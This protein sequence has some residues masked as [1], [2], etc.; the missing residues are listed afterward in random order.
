[1]NAVPGPGRRA[2]EGVRLWLSVPA[3]ILALLVAGLHPQVAS[4]AMPDGSDAVGQPVQRVLSY[5]VAGAGNATDISGFSG[6]VAEI[7]A[8]HRGWSLGGSLSFRQV[9]SGGDFVLWLAAPGS[10]PGFSPGCSAQWSCRAGD[11][12]IINE[13]RWTGG[14]DAWAATGASLADYQAMVINHEVGHLLGFDHAYCGAEGSPAP[15]MQ[16][17]SKGMQGCA[18]NPWPT[19]AERSSLAALYGLQVQP[20]PAA[21]GVAAA[22]GDGPQREVPDP[23]WVLLDTRLGIGADD[24]VP[25]RLKP[26]TTAGVHVGGAGGVRGYLQR[27][28]VDHVALDSPGGVRLWTTAGDSLVV[29]VGSQPT[30]HTLAVGPDGMVFVAVE[31]QFGWAELVLT[32]VGGGEPARASTTA[33][34]AKLQQPAGWGASDLHPLVGQGTPWPMA[35]QVSQGP[36]ADY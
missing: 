12:V 14:T 15:V 34:L 20:L 1:M 29:P 19:D 35:G 4:A 25:C 8:N 16:Q 2:L 3:L 11:D 17:Q 24:P 22:S 31:S 18:P 30:E 13:A 27:V 28:R 9:D 5:Q 33:W 7:L 36:A 6:R 32:G 26:G 10:V 21:C 23:E